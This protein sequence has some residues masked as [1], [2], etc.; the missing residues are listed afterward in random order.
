VLVCWT[1]N[2]PRAVLVDRWLPVSAVHG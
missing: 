1:G 2:K